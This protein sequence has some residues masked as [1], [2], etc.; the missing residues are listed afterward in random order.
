MTAK[1]AFPPMISPRALVQRVPRV[2]WLTIG[3]LLIYAI[4]SHFILAAYPD[5]NLRLRFSI[6]PLLAASTVV[7]IHVTG[8]ISAFVIGVVIL[9]SPKGL[10]WHKTLGW[11]WVIAMVVTASSSFFLSGMMGSAMSPIHALSAWT[12]IGLPFGIAAIRRR[13]I[14]EH[15]Q[16]M[17]G[18]FVGAIMIAGL[19]AFLPGRLM[20]HMFVTM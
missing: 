9:A 10:R 14:N 18:M 17:T 11:A 1:T 8:A 20:W 6:E 5:A 4:A 13:K 2:A 16:S 19:F 15:R 7:Q 3:A 12:L